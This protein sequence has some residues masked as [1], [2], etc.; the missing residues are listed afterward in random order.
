M[1]GEVSKSFE[2]EVEIKHFCGSKWNSFQKLQFITCVNA[3][4][5]ATDIGNVDSEIPKSVGSDRPNEEQG[6]AQ[7]KEYDEQQ[8]QPDR[9]FVAAAE[10]NSMNIDFTIVTKTLLIDFEWC[11]YVVL[12][13]LCL[14]F[15]TSHS[16]SSKISHVK[17]DGNANK[18]FAKQFA[19]RLTKIQSISHW[20]QTGIPRTVL[21]LTSDRMFVIS[22]TYFRDL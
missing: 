5:G 20:I 9:A 13:F 22:S 18:S 15:I 7:K 17:S 11:N 6:D 14:N 16:A 3:L 19:Y 10:Q 21:I 2:S 1:R 8:S 12:L 4:L